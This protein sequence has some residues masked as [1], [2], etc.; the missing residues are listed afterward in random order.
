[1]VEEL[2]RRIAVVVPESRREEY[3]IALRRIQARRPGVPVTQILIDALVEASRRLP[4][5]SPEE[6]AFLN[7]EAPAPAPADPVEAVRRARVSARS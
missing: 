3:G 4:P 5:V 7:G 2:P 6:I 1:M